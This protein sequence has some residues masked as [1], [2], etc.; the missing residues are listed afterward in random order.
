L[1][2]I[3]VPFFRVRGISSEGSGLGLSIA[4]EIVEMH[5]GQLTV[6]SQLGQGSCFTVTLP[7]IN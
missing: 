6:T 1:E 2:S 7:V 4:R 5:G 3:F